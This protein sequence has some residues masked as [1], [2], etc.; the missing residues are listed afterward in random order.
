MTVCRLLRSRVVVIGFR[1]GN[2]SP[3]REYAY[4]GSLWVRSLSLIWLVLRSDT[5]P[6]D[7]G[8]VQ[9]LA[10]TFLRR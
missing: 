8:Y 9:N 1:Q 4:I 2:D 3:V 5:S 10:K 7:A 6:G